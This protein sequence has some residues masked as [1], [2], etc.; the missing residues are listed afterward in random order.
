[1]AIPA[2]LVWEIRPTNGTAN[3]GGG[4]DPSVASPGTDYSQ[5]DAVQIA[6]TDLV[7]GAT[8]TQLTSVL[9]P[10]TS[11]HVGN[12]IAITGGTG[13]TQQIFNV[14]SVAAGIATMD[15]SV[16][17]AASV[18]GTGNLG[19]ARNGFTTG[20]RTVQLSLVAG[21]VA[22]VKN[23]AWNEAVN[24]TTNGTSTLPIIIQGYDTSRWATE[25]TAP[26]GSTRPTNNRAS[27]AGDGITTGGNIIHIRYIQVTGAGDGGFSRGAV[28]D[29]RY[30]YCKSY[31]NGG[32]GFELTNT[33]DTYFF[34]CEAANNTGPGIGPSNGG[35]IMGCYI[36]DNG[37]GGIVGATGVAVLLDTIIEANVGIGYDNPG[38]SSLF[39]GN[40]IDG[41]TGAAADGLS[42]DNGFIMAYNNIFSNNGRDGARANAV[43]GLFANYNNYFANSGVA[44]T[45]FPVGVNDK[46]LDPQYVDRTNGNFL[47]G[48]NLGMQ[49]FPSVFPGALTTAYKDIGAVQNDPTTGYSDPGVANVRLATAY[50]YNSSTNNRTGTAR[51]P[52]VANVKTGFV[53]D[54]SDSLTGTYD[55]SDRWTDPG[56][57][58]VRFATVY[59]ANSTTNNKTG[60]QVSPSAANVL[61]GVGF[62]TD[63]ATIGTLSIANA[64]W[65]EP[66]SGHTTSGTYG[67]FIK[68]ILTV[69]KF[70]G[71]K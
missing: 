5:Q 34:A 69:V 15:R 8:T 48:A 51:I 43:T 28:N 71:L 10:F 65:N 14:R 63:S 67:L 24:F 36:H 49:G 42:L 22:W 38:S 9:N 21:N 1:M 68:T 18:A 27:A 70:L 52:G 23:E 30:W 4:F 46:T 58:N 44:R 17:T 35:R 62:D 19:G 59:K 56:D 29:A 57:N 37:A 31:S 39:Y 16:G 6:Y 25:A 32:E 61:V 26:T 53:Y 50:K 3:A 47:I 66:M 41:N 33:N 7:I 40:T 60:R 64:V 54:S 11:A 20:T 12:N 55:G 45:N 2:S 13:F